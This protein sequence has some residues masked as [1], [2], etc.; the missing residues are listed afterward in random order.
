MKVTVNVKIEANKAADSSLDLVVGAEE[1]ISSVKERVASLQLIP[2]PDQ[3]LML[4][5]E[6]LADG[7]QLL[8]C[9]V[10]D[11]TSLDLVVR[12]SEATL[13]QQ[14]SDFLQARDLSCDELGLLY[15]YKHGVSIT[16]ALNTLGSDE[17]LQDFVKKQKQ[18]QLENNNVA[19]VRQDTALKPFNVAAELEQ[20]LKTSASGT[21]DVKDLCAKFVQKFSVSLS[22]IIGMKPGE[23]LAKEKELFVVSGRSQVSLRSAAP[24]TRAPRHAQV[25]AAKTAAPEAVV[26]LPPGLTQQEKPELGALES[27]DSQQYLDLHNKI[28]GRSFHSKVMQTLTEVV[29]V[30]S[31]AA[32]LKVHHAVKGGSVGKGTAISGC[33]DAEIVLFLEGLPQIKHERWLPPLIRGA[34]GAL[35]DKLGA[36]QGVEG[37]RAGEDSVQMR[38]KGLVSVDLR[39]SPIFES[40]AR[41]VQTLG[42]QGPEARRFY[43]PSLVEERVQFIARQPGP[44]KVTIRL[45][46]WW[47]DQQEWS[48]RLV[49]PTDEILELM[50]VYS[51]VQTKPADQ[52]KAIA[53]VMSLLSRF[54]ELRIVWSN[55]YTKDDVW[56]PLL[57]QRPLLMDP[58]NPFVN[59]A[60]PQAFDAR[61]LMALAKTT[62]FFW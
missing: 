4:N 21:M 15:C 3:D 38:V 2:F 61:E 41:T 39:F 60:D 40:Y 16:Q 25:Q 29:D 8:D 52:R 23:F 56:A 19:L 62:H 6:V 1:T 31:E 44:V 54:D 36:Q 20:I 24:P 5:G 46:K 9:G 58:V 17:K 35:S 13:V 7:Q 10:K 11:L 18:F 27:A 55:Y 49:R 14:L 48:G 47:R 45:L 50:A 28:C 53:N 32:F 34:A 59:I 30:I 22:S 57:R 33:A 12:A 43:S 42:E 37:I 51:A 26:D